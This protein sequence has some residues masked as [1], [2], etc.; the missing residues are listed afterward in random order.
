MGCTVLL[1]SF[2]GQVVDLDLL[3]AQ[4]SIGNIVFVPLPYLYS[5]S[6]RPLNDCKIEQSDERCYGLP[7]NQ[8][9]PV[10]V[11]ARPTRPSS[12]GADTAERCPKSFAIDF[13]VKIFDCA[14]E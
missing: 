14:L 7:S 5:K 2:L 9:R 12:M 3:L 8:K 6:Q 13:A 11:L 10:F 1:E 4:D